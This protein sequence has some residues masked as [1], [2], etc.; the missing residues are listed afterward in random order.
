VLQ[1]FKKRGLSI[2]EG[3]PA[4]SVEALGRRAV[5]ARL[6][7]RSE[8]AYRARFT[9]IVK[10]TWDTMCRQACPVK[11]RA[12]FTG[13]AFNINRGAKLPTAWRLKAGRV[14]T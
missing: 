14:T 12:Y 13:V 8:S 7:S 1:E 4:A 5:D 3:I 9:T 6:V 10:N 2:N 11:C